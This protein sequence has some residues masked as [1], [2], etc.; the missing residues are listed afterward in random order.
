MP[1][2][3]VPVPLF[4]EPEVIEAEREAT[5]VVW[6]GLKLRDWLGDWGGSGK[7]AA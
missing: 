4:V 1:D 3:L 7:R 6:G 5:Q 2:P